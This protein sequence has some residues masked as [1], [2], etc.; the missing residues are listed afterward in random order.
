MWVSKK[1]WQ[2]LEKRVTDLEGEAQG[3]RSMIQEIRQAVNSGKKINI[4]TQADPGHL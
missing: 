4:S 2:I 1:K 3:Q